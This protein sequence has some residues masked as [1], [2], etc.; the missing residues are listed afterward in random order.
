[1][2]ASENNV[3]ITPQVEHV[4]KMVVP[5]DHYDR[6][7]EIVEKDKNKSVAIS[8]KNKVLHQFYFKDGK[9]YADREMDGAK[10]QNEVIKMSDV[11]KVKGKHSDFR[12]Y[13]VKRLKADYPNESEEFISE[14]ADVLYEANESIKKLIASGVPPQVAQRIIQSVLEDKSIIDNTKG[15]AQALADVIAK[16]VEEAE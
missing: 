9:L 4:Y 8:D 13:I 1:M 14:H 5:D 12:E 11:P 6:L 16:K 7:W 2:S 3:V 10:Q 15:D